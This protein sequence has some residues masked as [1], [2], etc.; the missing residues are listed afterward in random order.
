MKDTIAEEAK[1]KPV[2]RPQFQIGEPSYIAEFKECSSNYDLPL[3]EDSE[4][5]SSDGEFEDARQMEIYHEDDTEVLKIEQIRAWQEQ[6]GLSV[7]PP[8]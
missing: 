1:S 6:T 5:I 4:E 3:K 7:Y 2:S 8:D